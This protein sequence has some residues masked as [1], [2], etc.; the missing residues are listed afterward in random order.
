MMKINNLIT[1]IA[2]GLLTILSIAS[3]TAASDIDVAGAPDNGPSLSIGTVDFGNGGTT[4]DR[5]FT[6]TNNGA[7]PLNISGVSG[8]TSEITVQ[9]APAAIVASG[10]GTTT[11]VVR[12]APSSVGVKNATIIIN[13]DAPGGLAAYR[14]ALNGT[15][16]APEIEVSGAPDGGAEIDVGTVDLSSATTTIVRTFTVTNNGTSTL[17]LGSITGANA[18]FALTDAPASTV[19]PGGGTTTFEVT[20]QPSTVGNKSATL[21]IPTNVAGALSSYDIA[22]GGDATIAD[23]TVTGAPDG[24]A[25][26]D[27]GTVDLGSG[28]LF[29][30]RT[31]TVNNP[32]T[33]TLNITSVG[34]ATSDFVLQSSP[35]ATVAPSGSTT[36][37]VRFSPST[38]GSKSTTIVL[39]TNVA[40]PKDAYQIALEGDATA[41]DIDVTGA[42]DGGSPVYFGEVDLGEPHPLLIGPLP[43]PI[44]EI[45]RSPFPISPER[46]R[47]LPSSPTRQ[48]AWLQVVE[49]RPSWCDSNHRAPG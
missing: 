19:A 21:R 4:V 3:A 28:T 30:D 9:T 41:P 33:S 31:F 49:Q 32:G 1:T 15:A 11:M 43:S 7:D 27:L 35:A 10:G 26:I 13:S 24:G 17:Q 40:S 2:V 20:F 39:N 46:I 29:I 6:I 48:Q 34:G 45:Q 25:A 44:M 22:L 36:F 47:T 18:D 23:I 8:A 37:T 16:V 38:T 5:S 14:I 12:F 42:P